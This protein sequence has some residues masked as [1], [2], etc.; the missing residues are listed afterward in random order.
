[1]NYPEFLLYRYINSCRCQIDLLLVIGFG[2]TLTFIFI[3][4]ETLQLPSRYLEA[5]PHSHCYIEMLYFSNLKFE[6]LEQHKRNVISQ[7]S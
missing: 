6:D 3:A 4:S 1:M 7:M 5:N 2:L